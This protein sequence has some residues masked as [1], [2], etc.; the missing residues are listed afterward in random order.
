MQGTQSVGLSRSLVI[1]LIVVVN[2]EVLSSVDDGDILRFND[3]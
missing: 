2:V 1:R 3:L